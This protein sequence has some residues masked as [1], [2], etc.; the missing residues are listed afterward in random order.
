MNALV[1]KIINLNSNYGLSKIA[2][3]TH[4]EIFDEFLQ[5]PIL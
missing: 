5:L 4:S 1:L 3:I 2:I